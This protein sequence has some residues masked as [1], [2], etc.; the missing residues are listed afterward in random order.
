[1][2]SASFGSRRAEI[3]VHQGGG[4]LHEAQGVHQRRRH[5]LGADLEVLDRALGLRA[6]VAMRRDLDR[7]EGVGLGAGG[8]SVS[9][10][11]IVASTSGAVRCLLK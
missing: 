4:L 2:A 8:G 6:P 1:M 5:V 9:V 11:D 3:L 7:P 10:G